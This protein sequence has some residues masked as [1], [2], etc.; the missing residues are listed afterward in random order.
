MEDGVIPN[1]QPQPEQADNA[2]IPLRICNKQVC[3]R[4][5]APASKA[6]RKKPINRPS[7][8]RKL[9]ALNR[10]S[11][12]KTQI[13]DVPSY[14]RTEM[15][16]LKHLRHVNYNLKVLL[17]PKCHCNQIPRDRT[18][19]VAK[20]NYETKRLSRNRILVK[21][22]KNGAASKSD[23][24]SK[25]NAFN[26]DITNSGSANKEQHPQPNAKFKI[27]HKCSCNKK[28]DVSAP[29]TPT[30][31]PTKCQRTLHRFILHFKPKRECDKCKAADGITKAHNESKLSKEGDA[32]TEHQKCGPH[33]SKKHL[34][35]LMRR[36][37]TSRVGQQKQDKKPVQNERTLKQKMLGPCLK[38]AGKKSEPMRKVEEKN[39]P[40]KEA[41][42]TEN[43]AKA[44]KSNKETVDV[45]TIERTQE[46]E[47]TKTQQPTKASERKVPVAEKWQKYLNLFNP[48]KKQPQQEEEVERKRDQSEEFRL[49]RAKEEKSNYEARHGIL[50]TLNL[51]PKPTHRDI[52][53]LENLK[54]YKKNE[55]KPE[56][57]TVY[58]ETKPCNIKNPTDT[59][60]T[61]SLEEFF[62]RVSERMVRE[63]K[64]ADTRRPP[65]R[66]KHIT[67]N[68]L[69]RRRG[70]HLRGQQ[71]QYQP[72]SISGKS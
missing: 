43:H 5:F 66:K 7:Q 28:C 57:R 6:Y 56:R 50:S 2:P 63:Q 46:V 37:T 62:R 12:N 72:R 22:Q 42:T 47:L 70:Q 38:C 25:R 23:T 53:Y 33:R 68:T 65:R 9:S 34:P 31:A 54:A 40:K 45:S 60:S 15:E 3:K 51:F 58:A 48:R 49:K 4:Q 14:I 11:R 32:K 27:S 19:I 29:Q 21:Q 17:K 61:S 41:K 39:M 10:K 67:S 44:E 8:E 1:V 64:E 24:A 69:Y 26:T 36:D 18:R 30:D 59:P 35:T 55:P 71:V 13:R 16:I 52:K 20:P